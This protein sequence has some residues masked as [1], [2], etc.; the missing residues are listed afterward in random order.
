M[1]ISATQIE[2]Y[3]LFMTGDWMIEQELLDSIS[4]KFVPNHRVNLGSAFGQVL[5]DPDA[6]LVPGGFR[7][8]VNG[9]MFEFG[10]DVMEPCLAVVDRSGVFEAKTVKAYGDCD[11]VSKADH[12]LGADLSEFKTTLSS[13]DADKYMAS[14][15]WRFMADAFQPRRIAYFV[16]CLYEATNGVIELRSIERLPLYPYAELHND[17]AALVREFAGYVRAKGLDGVLRARQVAA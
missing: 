8:A 7:I 12:L 4:G 10:M 2:A 17:C 5:E 9:E 11:V 13:F 1:R 3:R 14:C 16:F 6:Y 15:Q